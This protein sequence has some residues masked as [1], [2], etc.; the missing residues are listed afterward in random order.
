MLY[1][2]IF[3][4]YWHNSANQELFFKN[5]YLSVDNK[6]Y[7]CEIRCRPVAKMRSTN[8]TQMNRQ[9][10]FAETIVVCVWLPIILIFCS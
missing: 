8:M 3:E 1:L 5:A 6:V 7:K 9:V 10:G 4:D 2:L